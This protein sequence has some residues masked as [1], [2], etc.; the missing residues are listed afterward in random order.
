[1]KLPILF[2]IY[3]QNVLT[4]YIYIAGRPARK[5]IQQLCQDMGCRPEDLSEAMNDS[6]KW[7]GRVKYIRAS[8]T[9]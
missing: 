6:E 4:I 2:K 8:G 3:Q 7:K 5:Y 1:M 9:T